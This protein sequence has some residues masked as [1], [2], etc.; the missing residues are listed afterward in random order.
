MA[1]NNLH[2]RTV[3]TW[4][5]AHRKGKLAPAL[6]KMHLDGNGLYLDLRGKR[7]RTWRYRVNGAALRKVGDADSM[8]LGAAR[9]AV[10]VGTGLDIRVTFA[11]VLE[12][13]LKR[14]Q[15]TMGQRTAAQWKRELGRHAATLMPMPVAAITTR[16]IVSVL[17]A[18]S[19][20]VTTGQRVRRRINAIMRRARGQG[21][22]DDNPADD[23][24]DD[25]S[26][27]RVHRGGNHAALNFAD[28]PDAVA[29]VRDCKRLNASKRLAIVLGILT[30]ARAGEVSKLAWCEVDWDNATWTIPGERTKTGKDHTVPLSRQALSVL[31]EA[32]ATCGSDTH[33]FPGPRSSEPL[34]QAHMARDFRKTGSDATY[35]GCRSSFRTWA[36][37]AGGVSRDV[38]EAALAHAKEDA[39]I[40][41]YERTD[42]LEARIPLMQAWADFVMPAA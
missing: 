17:E 8:S 19:L 30:A 35:H 41:A 13:V 27:K 20:P 29:K 9:E 42:F 31:A 22:R 34:Q 24:L 18:P 6:C 16:D 25:A 2:P 12:E 15:A 36:V 26:P 23:R 39:L 1:T 10:I 7:V 33:A 37:V 28:V 32:K 38:A 5:E 3:A 40:A 4:L 21:Y 11:D 14:D